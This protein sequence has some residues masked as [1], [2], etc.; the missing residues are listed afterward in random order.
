METLVTW[1][2]EEEHRIE[3]YGLDFSS[4]VAELA[5]RRLPR[6]ADRIFVGNV[7]DWEPPFRFDFVRTELVYV[8][9]H[10]RLELVERLLRTYLS[11]SGRLV[12]CSYGSSKRHKQGVEPVGDFLR[13]WGYEV[14]GESEGVDA[15]SVVI[16]RVAW[17][18]LPET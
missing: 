1:A 4:A 16:T 8:P 18:D 5:R 2:E 10:R 12:V 13:G 9:P 14:A 15:N 17:T 6:W 11:P 7:I 3:P